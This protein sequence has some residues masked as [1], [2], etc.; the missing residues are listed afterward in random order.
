MPQQDMQQLDMKDLQD[1]LDKIEELAKSGARDQAKDLLSQLQDMMNNLQMGQHQQ[2]QGD[3]QSQAQQQ[4]NELGEILRQQQELMNETYRQNRRGDGQEGEQ[5][6]Q[7]QGQQQGEG[8]LGQQG[9]GQD[10]QQY[11]QNG[12]QGLQGL[13]PGQ[14]G[15]RGRLEQF[16][17]GLRGMGINPGEEFGQAGRSMGEAGDALSQGQ[18]EQAFSNQGDAMESLRKGAGDMMQQMQQAM[19]GGTGATQPGGNRNDMDRDP[20]GRPQRSA[21]PDFG[22]LVKVPDE[23]D[24]RRAREILEAIRKRLGNALSPQFEKDYLERLLKLN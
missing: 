14:Q 17:D 13:A 22:E 11:S 10:G 20:L 5:G 9:P 3:R 24:I 21:G 19:S 23:I 7:G 18:G 2:Q 16:M 8:Q 15:L 12:G 1:M 6:Q 4:M